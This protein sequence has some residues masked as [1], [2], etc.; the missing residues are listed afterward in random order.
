MNT[1]RR[2]GRGGEKKKIIEKSGEKAFNIT[3]TVREDLFFTFHYLRRLVY[4][5]RINHAY[6]CVDV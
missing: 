1:D 5:V 3:N 4:K 2:G 6:G